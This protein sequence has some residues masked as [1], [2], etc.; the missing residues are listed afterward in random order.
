M[1]AHEQTRLEHDA[2]R[3]MVLRSLQLADTRA[4]RRDGARRPA[5]PPVHRYVVPKVVEKL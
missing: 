3:A 4:D 5:R 1:S 2:Q